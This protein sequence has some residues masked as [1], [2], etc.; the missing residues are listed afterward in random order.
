MWFPFFAAMALVGLI[1]LIHPIA[2]FG[3]T[4]RR[5][6]IS[7]IVFSC[8]MFFFAGDAGVLAKLFHS[9]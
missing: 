2:L 3:M 4:R 6:L 9:Q 7:F 5:A 8:L 1:N